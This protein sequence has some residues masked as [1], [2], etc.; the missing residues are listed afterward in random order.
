MNTVLGLQMM[1]EG[2]AEQSAELWSS[3]SICCSCTTDSVQCTCACTDYCEKDCT[4]N[5]DAM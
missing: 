5:C 4:L 2:A 1:H 3:W